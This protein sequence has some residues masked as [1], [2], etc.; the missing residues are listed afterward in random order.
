MSHVWFSKSASTLALPTQLLVLPFAQLLK[1]E[2][3]FWT[4]PFLPFPPHLPAS[5]KDNKK[6]P[7]LLTPIAQ[8]PIISDLTATVATHLLS[9][10]PLLPP[11]KPFTTRKPQWHFKF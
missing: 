8:G 1:Q 5:H 4:L 9:H 10:V 3:S 7:S 2:P 11:Y 6:L